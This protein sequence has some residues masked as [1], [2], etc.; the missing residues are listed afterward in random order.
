MKPLLI[1]ESP[2]ERG[3]AYWRNPLSGAPSVRICQA[4]GVELPAEKRPRLLAAY[5]EMRR[6]FDC[7]NT[8]E[9]WPGALWPADLAREAV[10]RL[11]VEDRR[12]V[13]LLGRRPAAALG[14]SGP[15]YESYRLPSGTEVWLAPHTSGLNRMFNDPAEIERFG[16][17]LRASLACSVHS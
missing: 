2:S 7:A 3:D 15:F 6:R 9:R 17:L 13:V 16:E 5:M 14:L 1:G 8:I 4:L 11:R 10:K 12:S